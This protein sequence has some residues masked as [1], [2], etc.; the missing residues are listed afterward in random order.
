[1]EDE[2]KRIFTVPGDCDL[3][4]LSYCI[5]VAMDWWEGHLHQFYDPNTERDFS[6]DM[7]LSQLEQTEIVYLYDFG[8][9][10]KHRVVIEPVDRDLSLPVLESAEGRSPPE[11]SGGVHG[12]SLKLALL[13]NPSSEHEGLKEWMDEMG[14]ADPDREVIEMGFGDYASHA[15]SAEMEESSHSEGF[16]CPSHIVKWIMASEEDPGDG[17]WND[18]ESYSETRGHESPYVECD[19]DRPRYSDLSKEQLDW[20]L[21]W[22]E[23][24]GCC[25][26]EETDRGYLWLYLAELVNDPDR[27]RAKDLMADLLDGY[28]VSLYY[29]V[30][31]CVSDDLDNLIQKDGFSKHPIVDLFDPSTFL[32]FSDHPPV[33]SERD[34]SFIL[35]LADTSGKYWI[36]GTT[37]FMELFNQV[38][39]DLDSYCESNG[40]RSVADYVWGDDLTFRQAFHWLPYRGDRM[41][42]DDYPNAGVFEFLDGLAR[43]ILKNIWRRDHQ[44]GGPQIPASFDSSIRDVVNDIVDRR[45]SETSQ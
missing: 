8:D 20:Y 36:G 17:F 2:C 25:E 10:W 23:M 24:C 40:F 7:K 5:N 41:I 42:V 11:D 22:R 26:A 29:P 12:Y 38:L 28:E 43:T 14:Y 13:N 45:L 31:E 30:V 9:C 6:D 21:W 44:R 19:I 39:S 1:M 3:S 15:A 34:T 37:S 33:F 16:C 35:R 32:R 18:M 4:A 27:D